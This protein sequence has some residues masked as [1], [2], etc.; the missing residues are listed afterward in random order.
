MWR[1]VVCDHETSWYEE[2]IA[3]AGL[4][5][6]PENQTDSIPVCSSYR[7]LTWV[8]LDSLVIIVRT[9]F[10]SVCCIVASASG[11]YRYGFYEGFLHNSIETVDVSTDN[12]KRKQSKKHKSNAY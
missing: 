4:Q 6:Q 9:L 5:S 12:L 10:R 8:T 2:A 11:I 3:R 7:I 1:V